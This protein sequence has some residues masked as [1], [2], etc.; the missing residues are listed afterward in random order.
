MSHFALAGQPPPFMQV[1]TPYPQ[2]AGTEL[3]SVERRAAELLAGYHDS[4][5]ITY[6]EALLGETFRKLADEWRSA[7]A[8][9]S[10]PDRITRHEAYRA[11]VDLG[12]EVAPLIL[13][14]LKRR[15]ELWF[16]ALREL[17]NVDPVRPEQRGNVRAMADAWLEWG[18]NHGLLR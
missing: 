5:V 3:R 16:A 9:D 8:F 10:S 4:L 1:L 2:G 17:L 6:R 7:T 15:P 13:R 14:D 12:E 11:I 18:Q